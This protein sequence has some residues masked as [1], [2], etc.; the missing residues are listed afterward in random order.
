MSMTLMVKAM[1]LKVGNPLRKLVL[2]KLADNANDQGEC[3]PSYQHIADQCEIARSTVRK[4]IKDLESAGFLRIEHREGPKGN[5]SNL[6]H[7][8]L[9]P[10]VPKSTGGPSDSTGGGPSDS[11]RTSHSFEPV[12]E[13]APKPEKRFKAPNSKEIHE[14]MIE[15]SYNSLVEAEK[16]HDYYESN[17]WMVG[18]KKMKCWKAAVRN[19]LRNAKPL[20]KQQITLVA[21]T[22]QELAEQKAK[23]DSEFFD[24]F[25]D[26]GN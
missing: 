2:I 10:V 24:M 7:L 3:W 11:T 17:G 14:Y 9:H 26:M 15:R 13:P 4:H 25:R 23:Q 8:S 22:Q 18:K 6:Y 21:P 5:S 19:W 20:P 12:I 1:H 16:F